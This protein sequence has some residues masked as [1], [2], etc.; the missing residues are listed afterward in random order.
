MIILHASG[1]NTMEFIWNSMPIG[2]FILNLVLIVLIHGY[3]LFFLFK[4]SKRRLTMVIFGV[5]FVLFLAAFIFNL[6]YACIVLAI[7]G[8]AGL[9]AVCF[10]NLGDLR[11]FIAN[12]F[13]R[14]TAKAVN[15]G[16]ERIYDTRRH[17]RNRHDSFV[18]S[19][20][21]EKS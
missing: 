7:M 4:V 6:V 19:G 3:I 13:S 12:P 2:N 14:Q 8:T 17:C 1:G 15:F 18:F 20:R 11:K 9:S 21:T 5:G 16:I 10:A